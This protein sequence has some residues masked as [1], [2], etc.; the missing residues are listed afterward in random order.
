MPWWWSCDVSVSLFLQNTRRPVPK[1]R[2]G[3]HPPS[4]VNPLVT[5]TGQ[6]QGRLSNVPLQEFRNP[7]TYQACNFR[8]FGTI[9]LHTEVFWIMSFIG[10]G[11]QL[12]GTQLFVRQLAQGITYG[13]TRLHTTVT[14]YL[15][16]WF[17]PSVLPNFKTLLQHTL[18]P[19]KYIRRFSWALFCSIRVMFSSIHMILHCTFIGPVAIVLLP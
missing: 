16:L 8:L 12:T 14:S 17:W 2:F 10:W 7:G 19:M 15:S 5:S 9:S 13:N 11:S 3:C 4:P 18:Y 1:M 6:G